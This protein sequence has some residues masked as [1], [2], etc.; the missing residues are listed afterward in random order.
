MIIKCMFLSHLPLIGE[1]DLE[2][3]EINFNPCEKRKTLFKDKVFV[4]FT[5]SQVT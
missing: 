5:D 1:P 3:K 4:F 2:S